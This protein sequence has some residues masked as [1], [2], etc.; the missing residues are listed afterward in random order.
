M[1][2]KEQQKYYLPYNWG[3]K[4]VHAFSKSIRPE[5]V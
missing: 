3:D 4:I 1:L 2:R 5:V